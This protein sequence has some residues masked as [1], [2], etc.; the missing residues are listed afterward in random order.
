[1]SW[2]T[3]NTIIKKIEKNADA[4][5]LDAFK[6]I[7][8]IDQLPAFI[9]SYP[10]LIIVNTH[11]HN[12]YGEHWIAIF[13]DK[14]KNGELFD[15]LASPISNHVIRWMNKFTRRWLTN[16]TAYQHPMSATCGAFVLFYVLKRL[17]YNDFLSF[18]KEFTVKPYANEATVLK[19]FHNLK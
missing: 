19:Y 9:P 18:K 1:M 17:C 15:S 11:T 8:P 14:N 4:K 3:G 12:L 7:Y 16:G 13:I 5:T 10:F 2:L 6:G